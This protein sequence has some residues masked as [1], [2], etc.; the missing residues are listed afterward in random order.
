[1]V[2]CRVTEWCKR[3]ISLPSVEATVSEE[4]KYEHVYGRYLRNEAQSE[5]AK[6]TRSG[7]V[8]P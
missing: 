6:A 2:S 3:V 7:A 1:M 5:V 8:L 4:D